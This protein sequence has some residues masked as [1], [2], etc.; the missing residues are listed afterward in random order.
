M[1]I[2]DF[3]K[4]EENKYPNPFR[5]LYSRGKHLDLFLEKRIKRKSFKILLVGAYIKFNTDVLAYTKI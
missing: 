5:A 4:E 1:N 2:K 3:K